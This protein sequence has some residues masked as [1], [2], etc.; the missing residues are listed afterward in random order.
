MFIPSDRVANSPP[1]R[2]RGQRERILHSPAWQALMSASLH[3]HMRHIDVPHISGY[4]HKHRHTDTDT[5]RH[6]HTHTHT[7]TLT[8]THS[9]TQTYFG[10]CV[11]VLISLCLN[12]HRHPL[13][14]SQETGEDR[15]SCC[16]VMDQ[17]SLSAIIPQSHSGSHLCV[18]PNYLC[19]CGRLCVCGVYGCM[20]VS[21]L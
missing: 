1:Q 14:A 20:C 18:S 12:M 16:T 11:C 21:L 17:L 13:S 6:K 10:V 8:D 4:T 2:N 9:Q 15:S 3:V 7:H 19:V 5:H